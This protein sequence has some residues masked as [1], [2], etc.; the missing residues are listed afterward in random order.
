MGVCTCV[1]VC[2]RAYARFLWKEAGIYKAKFAIFLLCAHPYKVIGV[3]KETK[4]K[5]NKGVVAVNVLTSFYLF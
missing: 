5:D 1:C 2:A 4:T 3:I